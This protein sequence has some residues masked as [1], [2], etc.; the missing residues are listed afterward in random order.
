M[1]CFQREKLCPVSSRE[2]VLRETQINKGNAKRHRQAWS[3]EV[4]VVREPSLGSAG[5]PEVWTLRPVYQ[6]G[7]AL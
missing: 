3:T 7:L 5:Y 1:G 6:L 2:N 4:I